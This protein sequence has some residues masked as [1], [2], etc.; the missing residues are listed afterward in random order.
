MIC[1]QDGTPMI[2][3][4]VKGKPMSWGSMTP[5]KYVTCS[6]VICPECG[7]TAEEKYSATK[8]DLD[9]IDAIFAKHFGPTD[10]PPEVPTT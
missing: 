3:L 9:E 6:I 10:T 8:I 2:M 5:D 1:N 4:T 7:F